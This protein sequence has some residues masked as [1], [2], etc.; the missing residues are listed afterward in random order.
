MNNFSLALILFAH[1]IESIVRTI[2]GPKYRPGDVVMLTNG[3]P[4][5]ILRMTKEG[6][7]SRGEFIHYSHISYVIQYSR[8][9]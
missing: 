3:R 1:A 9:T 7:W 6:F 8:W 4:H 5:I 2:K